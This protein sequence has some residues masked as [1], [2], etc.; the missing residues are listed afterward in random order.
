M[1]VV[2]RFAPSPTGLL[3]LGN[4]RTALLNWLYARKHGGSFF[5]RFEDTDK[6]RSQLEYIDAIKEDL[7]WLGIDWNGDVLFQSEHAAKH[8]EALATLAE[9]GLAYRC[10]CSESKLNLD[11]KLATSRGLPP[12]YA[13]RCR[14]LEAADASERAKEEPFVWRLAIH[15]ED[16]E[17]VV[18]DALHGDVSFSRRDLDDPVVV[19]SDGSFTFLLPNAVDDA[20]DAITHVLRGDDHLTNSAYQ[21]WLLNSLGYQPPVYF[22][23]GLLLGQDGAKLSKRSGSHSVAELRAE[24][25]IAA[26]LVQSMTRLGHPNIADDSHDITALTND[27]IAEHVSTSSVRW[28]DD[29]M[30]RWHT[31][32]LHELDCELLIPMIRP[33]L[34]AVSHEQLV[35]F[36]GLIGKNLERASDALL[37]QRLLDSD[38]ALEGDAL[39]VLKGAGVEFY[40]HAIEAW[41]SFESPSWQA[42]TSQVKERTGCKGKALF[43]PLRVA[44]SGALHG[45]EMSDVVAFLGSENVEARLESAKLLCIEEQA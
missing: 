16:G 18:A 44:L 10:F 17:V 13:G 29:D 45:P 2:T 5:L 30:W 21:V 24:G 1:S 33:Y 35:K 6:D 9:K 27:F 39:P 20:L 28:S 15:A 22:H 41:Q 3:H 14:Y 43:M 7:T 23:H 4:V 32:L 8:S 25:L 26:A 42:L 36:A 19:R 34:P 37:F 40:Q 11:R 12:R 38:A 31:R